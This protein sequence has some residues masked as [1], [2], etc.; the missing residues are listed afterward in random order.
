MKNTFVLFLCILLLAPSCYAAD[1]D[2]DIEIDNLKN[3]VEQQ[4]T[5]IA[6]QRKT[7]LEFQKLLKLNEAVTLPSM[8]ILERLDDLDRDVYNGDF[9]QRA[10]DNK[11]TTEEIFSAYH[12]LIEKIE[13]DLQGI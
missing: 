9:V 12:I 3:K 5:I 13:A 11:A 4:N 10:R 7:A 6:I 8:Q 2:K 1:S